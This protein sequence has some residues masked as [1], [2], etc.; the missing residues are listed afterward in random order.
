MGCEDATQKESVGGGLSKHRAFHPEHTRTCPR[1]FFFAQSWQN[2]LDFWDP[3]RSGGGGLW[4]TLTQT[5]QTG[6]LNGMFCRK[7]GRN[8]SGA[9]G[10]E[11]NPNQ[12]G[13]R[14][15]SQPPPLRIPDLNVNIPWTGVGS[16]FFG[17][18]RAVGSV[19][20]TET[21]SVHPK[22]CIG[23]WMQNIKAEP[24]FVCL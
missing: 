14:G 8:L 2:V 13:T 11:G 23:A 17:D 12:N 18:K 5:S 4:R 7:M 24:F 20:S 3:S 6:L 19:R 15:P 9:F 10:T 21:G 22:A 1:K 16:T